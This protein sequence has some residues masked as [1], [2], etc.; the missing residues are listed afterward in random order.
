[1]K[2]Y[3]N[4]INEKLEEY[5]VLDI[6]YVKN[7]IKNGGDINER[8]E[9]NWN[10]FYQAILN[11]RKDS[12]AGD[13]VKFL[14]DSG[15]DPTIV[16]PRQYNLINLTLSND[17][18]EFN[19]FK[20]LVDKGIT[21]GLYIEGICNAPLKYLKHILKTTKILFPEHT[22]LLFVRHG[23]VVSKI[24]FML[25]YIQKDNPDKHYNY[26]CDNQFEGDYR[27]HYLGKDFLELLKIKNEKKYNTIV[28]YMKEMGY[29]KTYI[30]SK[31][32]KKFNL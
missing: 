4:F 19:V 20:F 8:D 25:D 29:Y 9:Y 32:R 27:G 3:L 5:Q 1:M 14:Y 24:K 31:Q 6:G 15:V 18:N 30:V 13:V 2:K 16:N 7:F 10:L 28:S 17:N 23:S 12:S 26:K 22:L 11:W 21:D